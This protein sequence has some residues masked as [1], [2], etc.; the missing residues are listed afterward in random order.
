MENTVIVIDPKD[1]VGVVIRD[2]AKGDTV[3][4]PGG[5]AVRAVD[6]IPKN[7]KIALVDIPAGAPV[8]KYGEKIGSAGHTVAAGSWVHT[9]N[10]KVEE[11]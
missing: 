2:V 3:S 10:L 8:I 9:H 5:T 1:N 7:H 4:G 11:A 6:D